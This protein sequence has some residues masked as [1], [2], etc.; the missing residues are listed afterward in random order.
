MQ[1]ETIFT[2]KTPT[3]VLTVS[4]KKIGQQAVNEIRKAYP[5]LTFLAL[6]GFN[7][8]GVFKPLKP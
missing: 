2:V 1:T 5:D 8:N 4:S 6:K 3:H 7:V